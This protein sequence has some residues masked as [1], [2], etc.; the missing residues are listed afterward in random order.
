MILLQA[1]G[2]IGVVFVRGVVLAPQI[3]M[4]TILHPKRSSK[5]RNKL[6]VTNW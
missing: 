2:L 5:I 4:H 1:L 3:V 6:W